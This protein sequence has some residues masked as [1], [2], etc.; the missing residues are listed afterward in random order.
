MGSSHGFVEH[1]I[2][3][4]GNGDGVGK[5][6]TYTGFRFSSFGH[7]V[8]WE[9]TASGIMGLL[10]HSTKMHKTVPAEVPI[11]RRSLEN[12]LSVYGYIFASVLGGNMDSYRNTIHNAPPE[13]PG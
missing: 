10:H 7:G 5:G 3:R 11:M 8:Q 6:E 13:Y 4:I 9:N 12:M 2:D 1:D